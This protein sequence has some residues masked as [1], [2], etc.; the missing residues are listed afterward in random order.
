MNHQ[1]YLAPLRGVTDHVFRSVYEK[2][3]GKFDYIVTPFVSTVRGTRVADCYFKDTLPQNNDTGRVIP[4]I[5]GSDSGGFLLLT[6]RFAD[7]GFSTV[8]WNLGCP[9][10]LITRKKRGSGLLPHKYIIEKFLDDTMPK[11][12]I[13]LSIKVRLGFENKDDLEA[14]I[15][16]F[17]NYPIKEIIIHPR[18]G[19]QAYEGSVD[20]HSF[21][22]YFDMCRHTVVYNGDI[23]SLDYF[24]YLKNRF[25]AIDRWMI[26]RGVIINP[27]LLAILKGENTDSSESAVILRKFLDEL[28]DI[29]SGALPLTNVLGKM[30]EMWGYLGGGLDKSGK[31]SR[32]IMLSASLS[33]YNSVIDEFFT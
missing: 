13:E 1:F 24:N 7:F 15:P 33:E 25:P 29:N 30:K 9:A 16:V 23:R 28:L 5:I 14:L 20:L 19:I 2:Y 27:N 4:Q 21:H 8:N 3:F 31:L 12:P 26:G 18:T 32:K 10:P 6:R 11:L 17:N 22:K